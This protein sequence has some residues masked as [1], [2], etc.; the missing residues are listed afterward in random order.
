MPLSITFWLSAPLQYGIVL[1]AG[2]SH[3]AMYIYRWPADKLNGTGVVTQH[4]ECHV[5]GQKYKG[6]TEITHIRYIG[7]RNI[8]QCKRCFKPIW[9]ANV[10]SLRGRWRNLRLCWTAG[11][12]RTQPGGVP[13]TSND[14]H[15]CRPA[16]LHPCLSWSYFWDETI[17]VSVCVT[18]I[19][20]S[21]I[22]ITLKTFVI[23]MI[24]VLSI[25]SPE[26]SVRILKE[27]GNKIRSFPFSFRGAIILSGQEEGA[28][29]WVTVNYLL[30]NFIKVISSCK[31]SSV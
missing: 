27:V 6:F 1:D 8:S 16:S 30:E 10:V 3:T 2:S 17:E 9:N 14:G 15:S 18:Q 23:V 25:T 19:L 7:R 31:R 12:S 20:L 29:G 26:K 22:L 11:C 4:S 5:K 21:H 13:E 24:S 28:Y